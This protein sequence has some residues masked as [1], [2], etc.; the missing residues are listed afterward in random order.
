MW[1]YQKTCSL[2]LFTCLWQKTA[3]GPNVVHESYP[4]DTWEDFRIQQGDRITCVLFQPPAVTDCA[5]L[6]PKLL[7]IHG[8]TDKMN[9]YL[10]YISVHVRLC[11]W[12][13]SCSLCMICATVRSQLLIF[14]AEK[15]TDRRRKYRTLEEGKINE[16]EGGQRQNKT[17]G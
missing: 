13:L 10:N 3:R 5:S 12:V 1:A 16:G 17:E 15:C 9:G 11:K 4:K 14:V 7:L 8:C 2:L 6:P